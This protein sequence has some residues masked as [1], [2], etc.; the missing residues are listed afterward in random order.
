MEFAQGLDWYYGDAAA[1]LGTEKFEEF[2]G[3]DADALAVI[4]GRIGAGDFRRSFAKCRELAAQSGSAGAF[5]KALDSRMDMFLRRRA[6]HAMGASADAAN[7]ARKRRSG[8]HRDP[9]PGVWWAFVPDSDACAWCVMMGSRG[10]MKT[11]YHHE[12]DTELFHPH[13]TCKVV[14][15]KDCQVEVYDPDALYERYLDCRETV[16]WEDADGKKRLRKMWEA[17]GKP[18]RYSDYKTARIL[19]EMKSRDRGWLNGGA[20]PVPS[21]EPMELES[22]IRSN[23][24]HEMETAGRLAPHGIRCD[25]VN[26]EIPYIEPG[27]GRKLVRGYADFADGTEIKT[28]MGAST[29]NTIDGYTRNASK[30]RNTKRLIFD[31]SQN[32]EM[33]DFTLADFILASRRFKK[34]PIYVL[35]HGEGLRRI[36]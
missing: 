32:D 18:G 10:W 19:A 17:E 1:A 21:Y 16:N 31:N 6:T 26:D 8:S 13:C 3:E 12:S 35:D 33:D 29:F 7:K 27:T 2:T 20:D 5:A 30:K 11:S 24:P 23:R 15:S 34:K 14:A 9:D 4:E 28:L 36:K 22:D 25:F